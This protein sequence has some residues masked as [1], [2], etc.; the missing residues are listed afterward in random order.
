MFC[1]N[2][3]EAAKKL[4]EKYLIEF[5]IYR[6]RNKNECVKLETYDDIITEY[7]TSGSISNRKN[8]LIF[9]NV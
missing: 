7:A 6:K 8:S 9:R 4:K 3:Q 5:P 2:Y 1:D